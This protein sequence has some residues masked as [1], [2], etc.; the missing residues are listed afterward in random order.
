MGKGNFATASESTQIIL[1]LQQK[2]VDRNGHFVCVK[3][4][5]KIQ[6]LVV[7]NFLIF[8]PT[9]HLHLDIFINQ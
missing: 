8:I 7:S 9:F 1:F 6:F 5:S 2:T 3:L 4:I